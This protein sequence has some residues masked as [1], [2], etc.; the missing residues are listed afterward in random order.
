MIPLSAAIS[1]E[2]RLKDTLYAYKSQVMWVK[3]I[4][5]DIVHSMQSKALFYFGIWGQED[6]GEGHQKGQEGEDDV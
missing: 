4:G 1:F 3:S 6:V 5:Q 2:L